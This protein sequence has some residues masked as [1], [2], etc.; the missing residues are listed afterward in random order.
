MADGGG[1]VVAKVY[2]KRPD[3]PELRPYRERLA[4]LRGRLAGLRHPHAWPAQRV[5]ETE[6]AALLLRQYL[7][8]SLA[9]RV[10]SRP[11]LTLA[12]KARRRRL[13][14][15]CRLLCCCWRHGC[16]VTGGFLRLECA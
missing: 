13:P 1:L 11:F 9:A 10:T 7:A 3:G 5:V 6:R 4:D 12:E 2:A 8:S 14:G 15:G 16:S